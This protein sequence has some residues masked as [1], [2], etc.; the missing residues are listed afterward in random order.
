MARNLVVDCSWN[1]QKKRKK[2]LIHFDYLPKKVFSLPEEKIP[3][4]QHLLQRAS[5]HD[6][7]TLA[8]CDAWQKA[9]PN[10]LYVWVISYQVVDL[11]GDESSL[12]T[13]H[14]ILLNHFSGE[15]F[16]KCL[17]AK[18]QLDEKDQKGFLKTLS[19]EVLLP[20]FPKR[21]GF[22]FEEALFFHQ[23]WFRYFSENGQV[24]KAQTQQQFLVL[25]VN[26]LKSFQALS[27]SSEAPH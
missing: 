24:E 11:L 6:L 21:K 4:L 5:E 25:L 2:L 14:E 16:T 26:T 13:I 23:L 3:E 7:D 27:F 9:Y 1:E 19:H 22:F 20:A 12:E 18:K 15:P 17:I 10:S 8:E